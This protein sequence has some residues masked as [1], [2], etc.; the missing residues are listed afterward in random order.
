MKEEGTEKAK[1]GV[2]FHGVLSKVWNATS[3]KKEEARD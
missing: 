1:D 3:S 2:T